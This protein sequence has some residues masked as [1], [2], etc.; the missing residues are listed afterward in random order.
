MTTHLD[1]GTVDHGAE[2]ERWL[3]DSR[4]ADHPSAWP[5]IEWATFCVARAQVHATLALA[6]ETRRLRTGG[7][8]TEYGQV[9][10]RWESTPT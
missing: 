10:N 7:L 8:L 9:A 4:E 6:H 3:D 2:A 5:P 1:D